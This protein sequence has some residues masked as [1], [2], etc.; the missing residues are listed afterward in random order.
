MPIQTG[1]R[2]GPYEIERLLGAGGM[3][4]VYRAHD[5]RLQRTVAIK[6]LAPHLTAEPASQLRF[7][8]EAQMLAA[9]NQ[10]NIAAIYGLE[11]ANGFQFL[12]LEFVGGETLDRRIRRGPIPLDAALVVASRVAEAVEVAHEKGI[13]HRDLKPSNIAFTDDGQVK[14]LDFGLAK[15][16]TPPAA[17]ADPLST[18]TVMSLTVTAGGGTVL[19]TPA[20]M[21][22]EQVRGREADKRSDV[23]A[24]GCVLYEML[25]GSQ[26]FAGESVAEIL[27]SVLDR[28]VKFPQVIPRPVQHVI[29]G[30][31]QKDYKRRT[32]DI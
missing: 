23:W 25:T 27:A 28:D 11:E 15:L 18:P 14:V 6:F 9:L 3:G 30:C 4:E 21:S 29:R 26:A 7:Q 12:I 24:F 19:G 5:T 31:L 17:S 8:R 13:I 20:Y 22:P 1:T 32:R 16:T 2:L 10:P